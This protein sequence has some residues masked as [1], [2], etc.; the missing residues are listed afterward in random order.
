MGI[1][2]PPTPEEEITPFVSMV[3]F[4]PAV[5]MLELISFD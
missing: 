4:A 1:E 3:T 5:K 2:P